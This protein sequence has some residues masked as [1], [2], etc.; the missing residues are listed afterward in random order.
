MQ[1]QDIVRFGKL[2]MALTLCS[3]VSKCILKGTNTLRS[4]D[5]FAIGF[6]ADISKAGIA[7]GYCSVQERKEARYN[8]VYLV[9]GVLCVFQAQS[10]L[11]T[12]NKMPYLLE[13]L[14]SQ[15]RSFFVFVLSFLVLKRKYTVGQSIVQLALLVS[16]VFPLA[17]EIYQKQISFKSYKLLITLMVTVTVS[18]AFSGVI[19][20]KY[21][22]STITSSTMNIFYYS[23]TS[24]LISLV[25]IIPRLMTDKIV[26]SIEIP[27]K[28][29]AIIICLIVEGILHAYMMTRYSA[30]FKALLVIFCNLITSLIITIQFKEKLD[31]LQLV[32]LGISS[33]CIG[34]FT[35]LTT[36][37]K[38][39]KDQKIPQ[40][41][42][43]TTK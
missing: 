43:I 35:F 40:T 34:I 6:L 1:R 32:S 28:V 23:I 26:A 41:S 15:F 25:G 22:K 12:Y 5:Y 3:Y 8:W 39:K 13:Q 10:W 7:Y 24:A 16:L 17:W 11:Y 9:V 14:I 33:L 30:L 29:L 2:L 18:G 4:L 38:S 42:R 36:T 19:F 31:P 20:E 21:I 27:I 37:K